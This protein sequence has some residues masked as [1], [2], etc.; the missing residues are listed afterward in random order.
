[1]T[2]TAT[3]ITER[4]EAEERLFQSQRLAALGEAMTGLV[5]ESRNILARMQAGLRMIARRVASD[6]E[7]LKFLKRVEKAH[8]DLHRV[9]EEVRQF[10]APVKL[11]CEPTHLGKLL[12]QTW[13]DLALLT[14]GRKGAA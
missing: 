14:E 10:A 4:K 12:Q 13:E 6:P 2:G 9:F 11:K 8:D 1:M 5:H 7:F 3:D